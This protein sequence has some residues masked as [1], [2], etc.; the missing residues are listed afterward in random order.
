MVFKRRDRLPW[1]KAT[2]RVF[3]PKSGWSRAFQYVKHRVRR[4]P[5]PPHR[6][7]RGIFA[8]IFV[9]FSPLFGLHFFLAAGLAWV[10]R[11]NVVAALLS[12][13]V[14]NP[15]TFL[16]IAAMSLQTGHAIFGM[17][18]MIEHQVQGTLGGTFVDAGRDL[19]QNIWALFT[20]APSDW[21]HL[22]IFFDEVFL[23]Y[24]VGGL[25]P[26]AFFGL[27]GYYVS[28]PVIQAYQNRRKG[29]I[30]AKLAAL[31]EKA[32]AK[33]EAKAEAKQEKKEAR[34]ARKS[35]DKADGKI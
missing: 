5:D 27:L 15:L 8:G 16:P 3:W 34:A 25:V 6:I 13:F 9:T 12:T 21:S 10:M 23:P 2:L 35:D 11:G 28:L 4:L 18:G 29:T 26:G 22:R 7:A 32:A 14:G 30:K 20:D 24:L 19:K 31:K 1:W 17:R 33:A